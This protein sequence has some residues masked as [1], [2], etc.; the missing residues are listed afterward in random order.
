[1]F[2]LTDRVLEHLARE[3]N[4]QFKA[5]ELA[6]ALRVPPGQYREFRDFV[7]A[8]GREGKIAKHA[9]NHYG[10]AQQASTLVGTL[11]VKTQGYAFLIVGEGQEDVFISQKNMGTALNRDV[12]KVQ[13]FARPSGRKPE[14]RVIEVIKRSRQ[15]IVGTLRKGKYYYFVKP[16]EM[17]LLQDI[18][19]P[20][21]FLDG[22]QP[23][24]KVAAAIESWDDPSHNPE[25]RIVKVLGF[26]NETGVDVLS[27]AFS[28]DLPADFP[29]A[30]EQAA[31][32]LRLDITPDLAQQR[33]DLRDQLI[34]T[35]DPED[36]K[37]FDDAV[38]LRHLE[39]GNYELGVHIADVSHYV[40]EGSTIDREALARGT[41]VYLVDRVVPM[42]PEKL[43]NELCSLKPH[44][45]RLTYSC[46][47][48]ITPKGEVVNYQI[49]ETIIHSKRRFNYEEV[50]KIL[51]GDKSSADT[52]TTDDERKISAEL[53]KTLRELNELAHILTRRRLRNGSLD[54]DT[55]EVK[56][57]LDGNG[58]PIDIRRKLRQDS[59]RLIEEFM[60]LANQT[61]TK[62][63]DL[64]LA[65]KR[66]KPPFIYRIH[67]APNPLK[68]EEFALFVKAFGY[69]F[70]HQQTITG[71]LLSKFLHEIQGK[72]EADIIE[73]V[74]LRSLMKAKYST[75]NLGHF[76][77]AFKHYSHFTSPIRRYPD[78]IVHRTLKA[79]A[80][81]YHPEMQETLLPKLNHAAQQSSERELVALEAERASVKMKQAQFMTRHLGDEF[82]G[83]ISG[84][85]SFGI[86]VEIPQFVVEGL[87]HISDLADD[88]YIFEEKAY[89][90]KGQNSGRI[91]RLGD[92][93]RVRVVR[94]DASERVL[95]FVLVEE[96]PRRK[97]NHK[98]KMKITP[99]GRRKK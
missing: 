31:E 23:G 88:Y 47:M 25:G 13:L 79:Y 84:V 12:V 42:L 8:L 60:L 93:V 3:K 64:K 54:F 86:F 28:F 72:P 74:M 22:A 83:L 16:D 32:Q 6:R 4:R 77:L 92:E 52:S 43:S 1:M 81:G 75:E 73:N 34:F 69:N 46:I 65:Q 91:Y 57:I 15:N 26:P 96:A 53:D 80:N 35:I 10:H 39:N 36:A 78:L 44:A 30:V 7:K 67:E 20:E 51:N 59:N 2:E 70:D 48:E 45:D 87:V 56:V 62:H 19:I 29:A 38:H 58:F 5:K 95:D 66:S 17:K 33:L 71:K 90:L 61:I 14:G 82:D 97:S 68:I 99:K 24:Q 89:R 11:H 94:A 85:V 55:P 49:A 40:A 37:D 18:Y 27:V 98:N 50:Q 76:G 21:E 9:R 41:S 63:V